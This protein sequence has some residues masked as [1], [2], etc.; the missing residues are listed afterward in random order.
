MDL[1]DIALAVA[2]SLSAA[3]SHAS[4]P[5]V[6]DRSDDLIAL[7]EAA[8][9]APN[10]MAARAYSNQMWEIWLDAPDEAARELLLKG[11]DARRVS[12]YLTALGTFDRLVEYCP[13][14]AE[15]YNQRA[16]IHYLS[17]GYEAA[18]ADLLK[19]VDLQPRHVGALSGLALTLI[20]LGDEDGAQVWLR[21]ALALNPW[22]PERGLLRRDERTDP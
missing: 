16:F 1:R 12:D 2:V 9:M 3:W 19:T 4:C 7:F 20:A 17:G 5:P 10:D 13:H 14:W 6:A 15:G 22:I 21:R 8:R 11:M 18:Y